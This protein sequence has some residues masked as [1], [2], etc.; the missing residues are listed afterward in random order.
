MKSQETRLKGLYKVMG[1]VECHYLYNL[2]AGGIIARFFPYRG[3]VKE[4]EYSLA[5]FRPVVFVRDGSEVIKL[6]V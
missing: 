1:I 3:I 4:M 2:V 5:S 6:D